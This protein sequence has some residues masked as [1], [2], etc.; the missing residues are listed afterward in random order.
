MSDWNVL[1]R[2]GAQG[3]TLRWGGVYAPAAT[4]VE[5][6]VVRYGNDTYIA[7]RDGVLGQPNLT[8]ADWQPFALG[9]VNGQAILSSGSVSGAGFTGAPSTG[10]GTPSYL[11]V[12]GCAV[13]PDTIEPITLQVR[14]V[15]SV[16]TTQVTSTFYRIFLNI[17]D[18]LGAQIG[19][20]PYRV[21]AL[22]STTSL[23]IPI[24]FDVDVQPDS[25]L[26]TYK[27]Q[28]SMNDNTGG[29]PVFGGTAFGG[30][31]NPFR[32]NAVAR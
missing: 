21:A 30:V 25:I 32:L 20:T 26:R 4:Y 6:T 1:A 15:L 8:P 16:G 29:T 23:L 18:D 14:G 12:T 17:V 9:G 24:A 27:L 11:D 10:S 22:T 5:N 3:I 31:G 28:E 7:I 19:F 13:A 2:E